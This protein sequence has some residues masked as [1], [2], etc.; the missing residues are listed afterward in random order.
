MHPSQIQESIW[1]LT[2]I[3]TDSCHEMMSGR[4]TTAANNKKGKG[5]TPPRARVCSVMQAGVGRGIQLSTVTSHLRTFS[6]VTSQFSSS[7]Q[8]S[9]LSPLDVVLS[10]SAAP[11]S[12]A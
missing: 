10:D 1:E 11:R 5:S 12:S 9:N 4:H 3:V 7:V 6:T 8:Y 2:D